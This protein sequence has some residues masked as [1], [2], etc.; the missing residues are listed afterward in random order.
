[1]IKESFDQIVRALQDAVARTYGDRLVTLAIF[2]SVASQS[3]RPDS[4]VD[5]F[6]CATDLPWGRTARVREFE[7][8]E[9]PLEP[10]LAELKT[11]EIYPCLSPVIKT[12]EEAGLGSVLFIDMTDTVMIFFDRGDFFRNLLNALKDRMTQLGSRK[13][14]LGNAWYWDL[15]PGYKPGME[16]IL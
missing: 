1:M 12:P 5:V 7:D 6:I 13:I 2:G 3:M 14:Q 11:R 10:L 9:R 8:V 16:V 15:M 4:D